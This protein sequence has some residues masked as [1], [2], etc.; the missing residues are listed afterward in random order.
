MSDYRAPFIEARSRLYYRTSWRPFWNASQALSMI[1][2]LYYCCHN[3]LMLPS[4]TLKDSE[5]F[6]VQSSWLQVSHRL[7]TAKMWLHFPW[8]AGRLSTWWPAPTVCPFDLRVRL[9]LSN[10]R[11]GCYYFQRNLALDFAW[12]WIQNHFESWIPPYSNAAWKFASSSAAKVS[13]SSFS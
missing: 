9:L 12:C 1:D 2:I 5:A 4:L 10:Y 11:V 13:C 6:A 8:R 7:R 3:S